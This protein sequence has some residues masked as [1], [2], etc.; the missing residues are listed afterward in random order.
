ML[1]RSQIRRAGER[2]R[3]D[4][5]P[6]EAD[7]QIYADYRDTFEEPLREVVETIAG[8]A[9]GAPVHS[10]LKRLETV[11]EKLRRS[12]TDLSRLEDIAGCRVVLPTMAEQ[13][14]VFD[15]IRATWEVMRERD[16][17]ATPRDG[18][19]ARHI[20][21]RVRERPVEVQV[22]TLLEDAWA[23]ASE[24][25]AKSVDPDIKYGGGPSAARD[26]LDSASLICDG[27]DARLAGGYEPE[28]TLDADAPDL[29]NA[30]Q[31]LLTGVAV[32][33]RLRAQEDIPSGTLPD[34]FEVAFDD[35]QRRVVSD[36]VNSLL[37]RAR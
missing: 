15:R 37:G 30:F 35:A 21:V 9:D 32:A 28:D 13:H 18:Y 14:T 7:R 12:P 5:T 20:V 17:Q 6:S 3:R 31:V 27:L 26:V 33:L 34:D 25:L 36:A 24:A 29:G 4:E 11:V 8:F 23:N 1:S 19:R 16:Y 10:R 2:L 22:R